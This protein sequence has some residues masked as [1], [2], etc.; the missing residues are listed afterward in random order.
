MKK[1]ALNIIFFMF[2]TL[3][4]FGQKQEKDTCKPDEIKKDKITNEFVEIWTEKL[5]SSSSFKS[6]SN[7]KADFLYYLSFYKTSNGNYIVIRLSQ[8]SPYMKEFFGEDIKFSK[9]D[10][11]IF[12]WAGMKPLELN[13]GEVQNSRRVNEASK[14]VVN[15]YGLIISISENDSALIKDCFTKSLMTGMRINMKSGNVLEE[16]IKDKTNLKINKKAKCFFDAISE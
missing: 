14:Q 4:S 11:I 2:I 12:G 7:G 3:F 16:E 9:E 6:A 1:K 15:T 5:A 8:T 13:I 10:K